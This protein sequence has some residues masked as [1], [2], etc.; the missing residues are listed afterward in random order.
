MIAHAQRHRVWLQLRMA[1]MAQTAIAQGSA[2]PDRYWRYAAWWERL[3]YPA[4]IAMAVVFFLM[5]N[6]PALWG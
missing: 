4:F 5:A 3:G 2:L 1:D 6:K